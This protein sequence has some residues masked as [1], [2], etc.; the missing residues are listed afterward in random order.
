MLIFQQKILHML[1]DEKR[2]QL[3]NLENKKIFRILILEILW[4][5]DQRFC[6]QDF[7]GISRSLSRSGLQITDLKSDPEL[8]INLMGSSRKKHFTQ[9]DFTIKL[10]YML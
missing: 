3:C 8:A 6:D 4:I 9:L 10:Y 7:F 5:R 2:K 1:S